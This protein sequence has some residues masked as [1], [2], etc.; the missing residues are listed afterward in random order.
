MIAPSMGSST[1][2]PVSS[3]YKEWVA[4]APKNLVPP[5]VSMHGSTKKMVDHLAGSLVE[6]GVR[7]GA[8][9]SG[10]HRYR[11]TGHGAARRAGTVVVGTCTVLL[12]PTLWPRAAFL[13]NALKPKAQFLHL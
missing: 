4:A 11:Q 7:G 12:G 6:R 5:Y 1:T 3:I 2:G 13:A 9:R 8:L 10:R